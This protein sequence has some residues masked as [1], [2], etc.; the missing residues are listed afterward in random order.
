[1]GTTPSHCPTAP[2]CSVLFCF[3]LC[4]WPLSFPGFYHYVLP[5]RESSLSPVQT[6]RRPPKA[7]FTLWPWFRAPGFLLS[8]SL[9][10]PPLCLCYQCVLACRLPYPQS[11]SHSILITVVSNSLSDH[12]D[13]FAMS[14]SHACCVIKLCSLPFGMPGA[15]LW[16]AGPV[17]LGE[18]DR[19]N[20]PLVP[21]W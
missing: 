6:P 11:P 20:R 9:G 10:F 18:R 17:V 15:L 3:G 14:G 1:M 13:I 8:S 4:S 5:L 21:W 7:L 12:S 2:G 16:I 19:C